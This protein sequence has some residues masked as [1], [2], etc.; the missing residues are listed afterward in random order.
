MSISENMWH[1]LCE[2]MMDAFASVDMSGRIH[3][4]NDL[5]CK[6]LGYEREEILSMTY[7]ELTP[8]KWHGSESEVIK[9]QVMTKG[10]SEIYEKEYRRKDGT[11]FPVELRTCLHRNGNGDPEAMWAIVRDITYRKRAEDERLELER[12]L[13]RVQKM[14]SLGVIAGGIA[15]DFNTLLSVIIGNLELGLFK[16]PTDSPV[17]GNIEQ[18]MLASER[19]A[20][21][22][23]QMLAYCGGGLFVMK[24]IDLND[25]VCR[26]A[27]LFRASVSRNVTVNINTAPALPLINA[28][29]G[30]LRQVIMNLLT[31][32]LEAIDT[33]PG[34]ITLS[35]GIRECDEEFLNRNRIEEKPPAGRFVYLDVSDTGC[36][37]NED[38]LKRIFDPFFSTKFIG[39]GLGM[40]AVMGIVR[41]HK[42]AI[43][44]G[45]EVGQGST[46]CV[47]FPVAEDA[48]EWPQ[49]NT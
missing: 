22:T 28:D 46:I 40:S 17:R 38:T 33:N 20:D 3:M 7:S 49:V 24:E 37:M 21:L 27:N 12:K 29:E 42:G 15:H 14:E 25:F 19:S 36:G 45:S 35:T 11:I 18:A 1:D 47:L 32:A 2:N 5:F 9:N 23:R 8:E 31:N 43:L 13:L 30:Q 44:L 41:V 10:F 48:K 34:V 16:L 26:N 6:L 39:R 4:C